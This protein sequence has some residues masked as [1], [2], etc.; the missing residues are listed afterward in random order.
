MR[1]FR[2]RVRIYVTI[3]ARG[4]PQ[5]KGWRFQW[6]VQRVERRE[7]AEIALEL[8]DYERKMLGHG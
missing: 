2:P 3:A 7:D 4:E 5:D 8:T 6:W 1:R